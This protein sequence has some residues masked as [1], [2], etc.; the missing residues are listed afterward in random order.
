MQ[1]TFIL[2]KNDLDRVLDELNQHGF[3]LL[4][5]LHPQALMN[6]LVQ[7]CTTHLQDFREAAIQNGV[8]S[9]IRSDHILWID[10]ET[11]IVLKSLPFI[12]IAAIIWGKKQVYA[13][14]N[15]LKSKALPRKFSA[16]L[17][18][19]RDAMHHIFRV[20]AVFE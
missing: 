16:T 17:F 13:N 3:S 5:H 2:A 11:S 18:K 12:I 1:D 8:V 19:C 15:S 10:D 14:F 7:E 4:D 6:Q 20:Q 9:N